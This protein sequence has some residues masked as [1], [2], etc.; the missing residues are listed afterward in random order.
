MSGF[1]EG[2]KE[3]LFFLLAYLSCLSLRLVLN[4]ILELLSVLFVPVSAPAAWEGIPQLYQGS[5]AAAAAR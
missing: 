4:H 1:K 3:T 5:G 2:G